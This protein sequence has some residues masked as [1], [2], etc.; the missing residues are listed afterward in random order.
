MHVAPS[1]I[2]AHLE[3][4]TS[5]FVQEIRRGAVVIPLGCWLR[6]Q[7]DA[8]RQG[9]ALLRVSTWIHLLLQLEKALIDLIC[10]L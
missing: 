5:R 7:A 8:L 3:A 10:H 2:V 6:D 9:C 1:G 4:R